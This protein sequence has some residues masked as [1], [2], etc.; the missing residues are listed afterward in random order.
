MMAVFLAMVAMAVIPISA[1]TDAD[2]SWADEVTT[3]VFDGE[4]IELGWIKAAWCAEGS[5]PLNK[6]GDIQNLASTAISVK[7]VP[8]GSKAN[9][10][11]D[12][13]AVVAKPGSSVVQALND[14]KELSYDYDPSADPN[15]VGFADLNNW[16]G[17]STAKARLSNSCA[18]SNYLRSFD[19][20][21]H[22]CGNGGGLHIWGNRCQWQWNNANLGEDIEIYFGY[23][24]D[25]TTDDPT[26][27][28]TAVPTAYDANPVVTVPWD[29]DRVQEWTNIWIVNSFEAMTGTGT[30]LVEEDLSFLAN[31][32]KVVS[33]EKCLRESTNGET[34]KYFYNLYNGIKDRNPDTTVLFYW[35]IPTH[36]AD[37]YTHLDM[38]LPADPYLYDDE[39]N[40]PLWDGTEVRLAWD[41]RKPEVRKWNVDYLEAVLLGN[42]VQRS[43]DGEMIDGLFLD[44][45]CAWLSNFVY[46]N[47]ENPDEHI[48]G[49]FSQQTIVEYNEAIVEYLKLLKERLPEAYILGNGMFNYW[50]NEPSYGYMLNADGHCSH[51]IP[52]IDG[53]CLEHYGAFEEVDSSTGLI[54]PE[55]LKEW[56]N[57][58]N[59][60][61]VD[62]KYGPGKSIFV[63]A[64]PGPVQNLN[65]IG[66]TQ[67][68]WL[69]TT[70][71]LS[72]FGPN[73]TTLAEAQQCAADN[74]DF[75]LAAYLC[76][77]HNERVYLS[78]TW[79]YRQDQG[80]LP[81]ESYSAPEGYYPQLLSALGA[82]LGPAVFEDEDNE[83]FCE[84]EFE[85]ASVS[86]DLSD[87][88]SAVIEWETQA[89][90]AAA[91][92]LP[93]PAPSPTVAPTSEPTMSVPAW[94]NEVSTVEYDGKSRDI[95]WIR[96]F[97]CTE[98]TNA[99]SRVSNYYTLA[100]T[101]VSVKIVPAGG[102]SNPDYDDFAV[103]A[104]PD[105]NVIL[106]LNDLKELSYQYDPNASPNRIGFA[107]PT[108][109][110]GSITALKRVID[111][112]GPTNLRSLHIIYAA[113]CN[114]AGMH[115]WP[116]QC[117]WEWGNVLGQDIEVF[118]G[119]DLA[120]GP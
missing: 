36:F 51:A 68:A 17:S 114:G 34:E 28:P 62:D 85:Y 24:T 90:T 45:L 50:F 101:A 61:V 58:S 3:E 96:V 118:F 86:V 108:N 74:L 1:Q 65:G 113:Q 78:Y 82:A 94:A 59:D 99:Y 26:A 46:A 91:P 77:V 2:L 120:E 100:Q 13:F 41:L 102:P 67:T 16:I 40:G 37:C 7:I 35:N 104:K 95:G 115:I 52:Y 5:N 19:L 79:W 49:T 105:S 93:T 47:P 44:G 6:L 48:R 10:Q 116:G 75:V 21:Y 84:R 57:W 18:A 72:A 71:T 31:N 66:A 112:C 63:K 119:F 15:R 9:A 42:P 88:T 33:L 38:A 12:S 111:G 87:P 64:F 32:Y 43:D 56:V 109:W 25:P 117:K 76:G 73:P 20:V 30:L 106:A 103:V 60:I 107:D 29:T 39:G 69:E 80:A 55:I 98:G 54:K 23:A 92:S 27:Q 11:Y 14:Y 4:S 53:I 110:I 97:D 81:G 89:P 70:D 22:G 83:F 8:A